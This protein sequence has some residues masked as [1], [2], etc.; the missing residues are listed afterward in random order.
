MAN[1]WRASTLRGALP[2]SRS[3]LLRLEQHQH[4]SAIHSSSPRQARVLSS[5]SLSWA[6]LASSLSGRERVEVRKKEFEDKYADRL[7]EKVRQ[8]VTLSS[9]LSCDHVLMP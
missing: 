9:W 7:Q 3:L 2:H 6:E 5:S 4:S 8:C 1:L